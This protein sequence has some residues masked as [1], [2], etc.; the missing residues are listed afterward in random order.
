MRLYLAALFFLTL[1]LVSAFCFAHALSVG[2]L[3]SALFFLCWVAALLALISIRQA[4][5]REFGTVAP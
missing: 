3:A 4:D 2:F 1:A 5:L